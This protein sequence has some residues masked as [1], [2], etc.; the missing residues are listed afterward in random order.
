MITRQLQLL[1]VLGGNFV[2][3]LKKKSSPFLLLG[4]MTVVVSFVL[5]VP[6]SFSLVSHA[7]KQQEILYQ[8]NSPF[9]RDQGHPSFSSPPSEVLRS[10]ETSRISLSSKFHPSIGVNNLVPHSPINING[11]ADF[12]AQAQNEGW[13]GDGT[14]QSPYVIEN[15]NITGNTSSLVGLI[16][17]QQVTVHFVIRN[18]RIW[19]NAATSGLGMFLWNVS[20]G[21]I[22]N[23]EIHNMTGRDSVGI[24]VDD[25]L[26]VIIANNTVH[27]I[28]G[29]GGIVTRRNL[30]LIINNNTIYQVPNWYGLDFVS[31]NNSIISQNHIYQSLGGIQVSYSLNTTIDENLIHDV[32]MSAIVTMT[33]NNV[34]ITN[35]D[36]H[37]NQWGIYVV[38][39]SQGLYIYNNSAHHNMAHGI[40]ISLHSRNA[41]ILQNSVFQNQGQGI[42]FEIDCDIGD[43]TNNTVY[44]NLDGIVIRGTKVNV[45]HNNI[46]NSVN[47]QGW[48]E[49]V[50]GVNTWDENYWSDVRG[51]VDANGDGFYDDPYFI[52]NP[53]NYPVNDSHPLVRPLPLI[54]TI[55]YGAEP[56][57]LFPQRGE[58]LS[59]TI[60][61]S[62]QPA[63]DSLFHSFNYT[64]YLSGDG[65]LTWSVLGSFLGSNET[66]FTWD[67]TTVPDG[68]SYWLQ[69]IADDGYGLR[70]TTRTKNP[71]EIDNVPNS[72]T[73]SST[74]LTSMRLITG[75]FVVNTPW[76]S[77]LMYL[78]IVLSVTVIVMTRKNKKNSD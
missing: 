71:F 60:T 62:W 74:T 72:A 44:G 41:T 33:S 53:M 27:D 9:S 30:N 48:D 35:N 68:S 61:I 19:G 10:T 14:P 38:D 73:S 8:E 17:I 70:F 28:D 18:C 43:I 51:G 63:F 21:K 46:L 22:V 32:S 76:D 26:N 58:K 55:H 34:K 12:I 23:N 77:T 69:L 65:G 3:M 67:T 4:I 49:N 78:A 25:S 5:I 75:T 59:G 24:Q 15:Y 1:I 42:I 36:A 37:D 16:N 66:S 52:Q 7:A 64:I 29:R 13:P 57:I 54:T 31:T 2:Y 50:A 39:Q 20:N 40:L 45:S 56:E 47:V 6:P 11:D